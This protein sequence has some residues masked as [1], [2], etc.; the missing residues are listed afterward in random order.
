MNKITY[1]LKKDKIR[2]ITMRTT[3][4]SFCGCDSD[5]VD[6][7]EYDKDTMIVLG[8]K[9]GDIVLKL[10]YVDEICVENEED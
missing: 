2:K 4:G 1:N 8:F 6:Y 3:Y 7:I 9:D 10:W 5:N